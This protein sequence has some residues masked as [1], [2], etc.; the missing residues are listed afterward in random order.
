MLKYVL[1]RIGMMIPVILGV[2]LIVFVV[3]RSSGDPVA[4]ILGANATEEQYAA[5]RHRLGLDRSLPEQFFEYVK[6]VVTRFDL[7][8]SFSSRKPVSE[9]VLKRIPVTLSLAVISLVI[10][11]VFGIIFGVICAIN[12]NRKVDYIVTLLALVVAS[13]PNFWFAL[14]LILIFAVKLGVLPATGLD[15][16]KNWILPSVVMG[17]APISNLTRTTRSSMLEVIRQDYIR[18]AKSKGISS[19]KVIFKHALKNALF[20]VITV[21]G[22]MAS[23]SI[24]GQMVVET[25]FTIPGV[26]S[27]MM[28]AIAQKDYPVVQGTVLVLSLMV[29]FINLIVDIAYGFA[30]P[31]I[32]ASYTKG[33]SKKLKASAQ[34]QEAFK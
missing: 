29:C 10:A 5:E 20:P 3:N 21:F 6:G 23:L 26:G 18:T 28:A 12:Q 27:Y 24:G 30:D 14:M 7:G 15:T 1:R 16:W 31:R 17:L 4:T 32:R 34:I 33:K 19:N 8:T 22:F 2:L 25:V 9:E 11:S 13:L